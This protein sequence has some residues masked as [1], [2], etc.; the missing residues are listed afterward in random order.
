MCVFGTFVRFSLASF[1]WDICAL[2]LGARGYFLARLAAGH[3]EGP[4]VHHGAGLGP[5]RAPW[6]VLWAFKV[7]TGVPSGE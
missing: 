1:F 3:A 7:I 2:F 6:R 4:S 5:G